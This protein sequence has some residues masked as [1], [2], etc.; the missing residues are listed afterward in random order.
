MNESF[1]KR[2]K[3]FWG[4][5]IDGD[6]GS[7]MPHE[8]QS[9]PVPTAFPWPLSSKFLQHLEA[10]GYSG[11]ARKSSCR[12]TGGV[13]AE[14]VVLLPCLG[15]GGC[16]DCSCHS[17]QVS[18]VTVIAKGNM[19]SGPED[20]ATGKAVFQI[21]YELVGDGEV[22]SSSFHHWRISSSPAQILAPAPGPLPYPPLLGTGV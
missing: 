4:G 19:V 20:G 12:L 8:L 22:L 7:L 6:L 14:A 18:S 16:G 11:S 9:T 2:P 1:S 5:N 17:D 21:C 3:A 15:G 13:W 10:E